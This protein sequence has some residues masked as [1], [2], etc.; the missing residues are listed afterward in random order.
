MSFIQSET[1]KGYKPGYFLADAEHCTRETRTISQ[2]H[3][4]VVTENG[5]KHV[6]AGAMYPSND[7]NA[8]G[9]LYEDVDVTYGDM[10]GSVVTAGIVYRD[11]LPAAA[12]AAVTALTKITFITNA[13]G[14]VRP[15]FNRRELGEI[16]V[17][18]A[19]GT[20]TGKTDVSI[21]YTLKPGEA[22]AYKIDQT[23][24]PKVSLGEILPTT[25]TGAWEVATFPLD[26]LE[27]TADWKITVAIIDSI[28]AAVAAGSATID[29]K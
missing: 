19:E 25:G 26:E 24:A 15:D 23:T 28:G 18:S 13:P 11:R 10:P 14:I 8:T 7:G 22:A 16:T 27:A 9:I 4:Q 3:A 21:N 6:P 17:V 29:V 1:N 5:K 12:D 2:N 20:G